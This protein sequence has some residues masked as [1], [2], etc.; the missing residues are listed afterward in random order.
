MKKKNAKERLREIAIYKNFSNFGTNLF[1]IRQC[2]NVFKN[3][4]FFF[5]A[6]FYRNTASLPN[7][8][9]R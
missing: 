7:V 5:W 4:E 3:I 8:C 1:F 6:V 2:K 9:L